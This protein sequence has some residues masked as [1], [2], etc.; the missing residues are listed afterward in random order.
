MITW[1]CSGRN[2]APQPSLVQAGREIPRLGKQGVGL[3]SSGMVSAAPSN[4]IPDGAAAARSR[5]SPGAAASALLPARPAAPGG[6]AGPAPCSRRWSTRAK[7]PRPLP[8]SVVPESPAGRPNWMAA[9]SRQVGELQ[10]PTAQGFW[11]ASRSTTFWWLKANGR[12]TSSG[13]NNN[14][15]PPTRS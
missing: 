12:E 3:H 15:Q 5:S 1:A 7:P 13:T 4:N 10:V 9:F 6:P 2:G 14:D 8:R 11:I